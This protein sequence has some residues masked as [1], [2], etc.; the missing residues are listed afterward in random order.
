MAAFADLVR[1]IPTLGGTTDW[2]YSSAVGGCQSPASAG[3]L[4]ATKYKYYAVSND[5]TQWE[6]GEGTYTVS[7]TTL[8]RTTVL[9]NS[10]ATGTASGQSG[11]GTK[12]SFSTVPQVAIIGIAEDLISVEIANSFSTAQQTQARANIGAAPA[13]NQLTN[14]L[15]S[16]V[17]LNSTS[18]YF[19]GPSVAQGTSGTWYASG[20]VVVADSSAG[21]AIFEAKLWDGT[22]VFASTVIEG[23]AALNAAT[24]IS[25]SGIIT[26]PA[27]NIRIS[28]KD[29]T[30]TSGNIFA[31][32]SGNSKDSTISAFRIA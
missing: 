25:L 24:I 10:S 12:I 4:N 2:V 20:S 13:A 5:L 17:A 11:A 32:A 30:A 6:I 28:V 14:S 18:T 8:T 19:D 15:G 3:V 21:N 16:N 26:T 31:N 29:I 1:F 27:G 23:A 9:Y 22:T 7:T